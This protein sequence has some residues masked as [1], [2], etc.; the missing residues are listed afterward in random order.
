[1]T[2]EEE[3]TALKRTL[4]LQKE[5]EEEN[6]IIFAA[7]KP[8]GLGGTLTAMLIGDKKRVAAML[9]SA[10]KENKDIHD[11]LHC[12]VTVYDSVMEEKKEKKEGGKEEKLAAALKEL[13]E[14]LKK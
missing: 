11:L 13:F 8:K 6:D 12:V 5:L 3:S 10:M 9:C 4:R 1:M 2:Q 7:M 14:E